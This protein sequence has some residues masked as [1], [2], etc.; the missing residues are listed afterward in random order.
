MGKKKIAPQAKREAEI[1]TVLVRPVSKKIKHLE[2][3]RLYV[4]ATYNNTILTVTDMKG[5]VITWGSAGSIGFSGPKKAT[6]FVASKI[7]SVIAEKLR[8]L[9]LREVEVY[10]KGVGSGRDSALRSLVNQGF[11]ITSIKDV[12]PIPHNGPR[13]AKVR[14]V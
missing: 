6:P 9:G 14:R 11:A 4:N 10:V 7:V 1:G 5:N 8:P 3:A 2:R 13:P 12:T